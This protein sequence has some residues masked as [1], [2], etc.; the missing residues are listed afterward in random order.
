MNK[1]N[2]NSI[3]LTPW[4]KIMKQVW[5]SYSLRI[6]QYKHTLQFSFL[7]KFDFIEFLVIWTFPKFYEFPCCRF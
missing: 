2:Q 1:I 5:Y 3:I 7:F 4:V 6:F